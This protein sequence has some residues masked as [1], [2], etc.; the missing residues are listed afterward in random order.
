MATIIETKTAFEDAIRKDER[1]R[2]AKDAAKLLKRTEALM[3]EATDLL[4]DLHTAF[5]SS[6]GTD[7]VERVAQPAARKAP[8]PKLSDAELCA[9]EAR[10]HHESRESPEQEISVGEARGG[11]RR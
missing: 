3:A 9:A 2:I 6:N 5:A 4:R 1:A 10:R 11:P 8:S 7:L